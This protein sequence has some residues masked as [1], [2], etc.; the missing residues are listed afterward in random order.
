[1]PIALRLAVST[2]LLALVFFHVDWD[3]VIA[4]LSK[5]EWRWMVFAFVAFNLATVFAS[6][7]W[8][9][10]LAT[11]KG[12]RAPPTLRAAIEAT[13]VSLWLSNFLPTAFGGDVSRVMAGRRAGATLPA[14]IASAVLDRVLGFT[15]FTFMFFGVEGVLS[16]AQGHSTLL[17]PVSAMLTIGFVVMGAVLVASRYIVVPRRWLRSGAVRFAIRSV[18]VLRLLGVGPATI[19]RIA[20]ASFVATALGVI[21]YW[22]AIRCVTSD[23]TLPLALAAAVLGTIAS[24]LPISLSGWGVREGAVALVLTQVSGMSS[25]DASLVAILNGAV[26]AM[27][28]LVGLAVS[29]TVATHWSAKP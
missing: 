5:A 3:G 16:V 29:L 15:T 25:S 19:A 20:G 21:A 17:L 6:R 14:S 1:M 8:Q 4:A 23:A 28:S 27:T 11:S 7:R 13:Y 9:L 24:A 12:C 26:I 10:V 18:V 22:G 2:A